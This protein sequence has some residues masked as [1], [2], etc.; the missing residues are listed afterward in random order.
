MTLLEFIILLDLALN[1]LFHLIQLNNFC[2]H[3]VKDNLLR[4][5][6]RVGRLEKTVT[7][8]NQQVFQRFSEIQSFRIQPHEKTEDDVLET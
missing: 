5:M 4:L 1:T 8:G 6:H 2:N 7:E 3:E